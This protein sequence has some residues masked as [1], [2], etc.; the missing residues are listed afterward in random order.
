MDEKW[1]SACAER[2]K[3]VHVNFLQWTN[4]CEEYKKKTLTELSMI[5]IKKVL[6]V[7]DK[8][9]SWQVHE[10]YRRNKCVF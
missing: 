8:E 9:S 10:I 5:W 6:E 4:M 3:R 2:E 7:V 1:G